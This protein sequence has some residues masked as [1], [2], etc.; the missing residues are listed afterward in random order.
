MLP[1]PSL[2]RPLVRQTN[3]LKEIR[4]SPIAAATKKAWPGN[5]PWNATTT[6]AATTTVSTAARTNELPPKMATAPPTSKS[7]WKRTRAVPLT[8]ENFLDLLDGRTPT[9]QELGFLSPEVS[10]K[11]E[12]ELS[13]RLTPYKHNTGPLLSKVGVAQ[14]EYQAQAAIDFKNRANGSNP[15]SWNIASRVLG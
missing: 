6:R 11:F 8:R 4:L 7:Q 14:F 1:L 12:E 15:Y 10:R 3:A 13:P 9:I 5:T 2:S